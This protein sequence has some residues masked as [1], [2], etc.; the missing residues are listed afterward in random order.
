MGR[1]QLSRKSGVVVLLFFLLVS[2]LCS[3]A[4]ADIKITTQV[5]MSSFGYV[6][7]ISTVHEYYRPDMTRSSGGSISHPELDALHP[8]SEKAPDSY[9]IKRYDKGIEWIIWDF[10]SS[11]SEVSLQDSDDTPDTSRSDVPDELRKLQESV[12][13]IYSNSELGDSLIGS[14]ACRGLRISAIES[15][16]Q[17]EMEID[18]WTSRDGGWYHEF[19]GHEANEELQDDR[20]PFRTAPMVLLMAQ[21]FG[22]DG[23]ELRAQASEL[24]GITIRASLKMF[25]DPEAILQ[26][27]DSIETVSEDPQIAESPQD[28]YEQTFDFL[29][30]PDTATVA[31]DPAALATL[32]Q[33]LL[34]SKEYGEHNELMGIAIEITDVD[35]SPLP[36]SLFEVPKGYKK[37]R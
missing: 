19:I 20:N 24:Q 9:S 14:Y 17:G 18:V 2:S 10:D 16:G 32:R 11:Y 37:S 8:G 23:E 7:A 15:T 22:L 12:A 13:Y 28:P 30:A 35:L 21:Q 33:T 5:D 27:G 4:Y 31:V 3:N 26:M 25:F 36:D 29:D 1:C 34:A 6:L